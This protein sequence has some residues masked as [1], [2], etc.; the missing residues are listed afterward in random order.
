MAGVVGGA[1]GHGLVQGQAQGLVEGGDGIARVG[2]VVAALVDVLAVDDAP[3]AGLED[4][5]VGVAGDAGGADLG[6]E[7][8]GEGHRCVGQRQAAD[9]FLR[10]GGPGGDAGEVVDAEI[11]D[12]EGGDRVDQAEGAVGQA[13]VGEAAQVV[14]AARAGFPM[15]HEGPFRLVL[16][17]G[18]GD[19]FA[20]DGLAVRDLDHRDGRGLRVERVGGEL[21]GGGGLEAQGQRV[22]A[23]EGAVGEG[24]DPVAGADRREHHVE[25]RPAGAR[26]P[27]GVEV[28]GAPDVAQHQLAFDHAAQHVGLHVVGDPGGGEALQHAGIGVAG[29]G[30]R[31]EGVGNVELGKDGRGHGGLL[32]KTRDCLTLRKAR[33]AISGNLPYSCLWVANS[34]GEN[35]PIRVSIPLHTGK[36]PTRK[37]GKWRFREG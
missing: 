32:A 33:L 35:L 15:R 30:A 14:D 17:K 8:V 4:R 20:G 18:G 25:R 13:G 5:V 1:A 29:A 16:G 10:A 11:G 19:G 2:A 6:H 22:D 34:I 27:E 21:F 28:V 9:A 37:G 24:H 7:A 12:T 31:R 23:R 26:N 36:S 3:V